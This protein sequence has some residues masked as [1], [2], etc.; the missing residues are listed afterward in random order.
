MDTKWF[1]GNGLLHFTLFQDY[2]YKMVQWQRFTTFYALVPLFF[3]RT[4]ILAL[5]F[6]T[7]VLVLTFLIDFFTFGFLASML[8]LTFLDDSFALAFLTPVLGLAFLVV[9]FTLGFLASVLILDFFVDFFTSA[10]SPNLNLWLFFPSSRAFLKIPFSTPFFKAKA[11][12]MEAF[13]S[14]PTSWTPCISISRIQI[15]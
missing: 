15:F 5:G 6:L 13:F 14:S 8:V 9:F 10:F 3:G 12:Y 2:G 11:R 4:A 7:P 1:N